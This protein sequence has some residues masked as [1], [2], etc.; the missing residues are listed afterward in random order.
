MKQMPRGHSSTSQSSDLDLIL[1]AR[2]LSRASRYREALQ[3]VV[4][5]RVEDPRNIYLIALEKQGI[6]LINAMKSGSSLEATAEIVSSLPGLFERAMAASHRKESGDSRARSAPDPE[7]GKERKLQ[8]LKASYFHHADDFIEHGDYENALAEVRR[9]LIIEPT[10]SVAT[11]Y[12]EKIQQLADFQA[13]ETEEEVEGPIMVSSA[14]VVPSANPSVQ[15]RKSKTPLLVAVLSLLVLSL[16]SALAFLR[17]GES[18]PPDTKPEQVTPKQTPPPVVAQTAIHVDPAPQV[19]DATPMVKKES[20]ISTGIRPPE[21]APEKVERKADSNVVAEAVPDPKV[22]QPLQNP[23]NKPEA[24]SDVPVSTQTSP[25]ARHQSIEHSTEPASSEP[26]VPLQKEA[27]IIRLEKP[28]ITSIV[29]HMGGGKVMVRVQI[30]A[31][32]RPADAKILSSTNSALNDAVIEAVMTSQYS[33][34]M[35]T[36]GTVSSSLI[37][38]FNFR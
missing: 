32:G 3:L 14:Q 26:F 38:P 37:I 23:P 18:E 29:E 33:P 1:Q 11:K 20:L 31:L 19:V 2:E 13:E 28:R 34:A 21:T 5:A 15:P 36:N 4:S 7:T 9:V 10:N 35:M 17:Q 16:V 25:I 8:E 6:R 30:D 24:H 22:A 27:Q 12:E